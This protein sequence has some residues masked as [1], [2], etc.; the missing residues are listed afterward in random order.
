[1]KAQTDTK[2]NIKTSTS[3]FFKFVFLKW[4]EALDIVAWRLSLSLWALLLVTSK[5]VSNMFGFIQFEKGEILW[6]ETSTKLKRLQKTWTMAQ[7]KRPQAKNLST[8][9]VVREAWMYVFLAYVFTTTDHIKSFKKRSS[10]SYFVHRTPELVFFAKRRPLLIYVRPQ[11][12]ALRL[13]F[14]A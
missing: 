13:F 2:Y 1:M 3:C 11:S 10:V 14:N 7:L 6:K 12:D 5:S 4:L 8:Y 9:P